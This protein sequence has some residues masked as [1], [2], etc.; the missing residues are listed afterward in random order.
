VGVNGHA[1]LCQQ[2]FVK[3]TPLCAR[4]TRVHRNR[5]GNK[6]RRC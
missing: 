2:P 3:L 1:Q 5:A 4:I 6:P